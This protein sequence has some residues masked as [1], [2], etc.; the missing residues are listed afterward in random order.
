[1]AARV[2][3]NRV[4]ALAAS[5]AR[6]G[7]ERRL[8]RSPAMVDARRRRERQP[9]CG[10]AAAGTAAGCAA[11]CC[12][13][14]FAVVELVVL[15]AVR[16]PAALCQRTIRS[17]RSRRRAARARR[18]KEMEDL[19]LAADASPRTVAAVRAKHAAL[20][21]EEEQ[22][23]CHWPSKPAAA[24]A[25]KE[26]ELAEEEKE[27]WARFNATGFWRSPSQREEAW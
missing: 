14:P 7:Q 23:W 10:E 17:Q 3:S 18:M 13:I 11:V 20:V 2:H 22:G 15:A 1:M 19:I 6:T 5:P 8:R 4:A 12:C 21:A 24:A 27:V 25:E 26:V 16:A 9:R